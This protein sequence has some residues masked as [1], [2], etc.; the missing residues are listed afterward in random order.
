[1]GSKEGKTLRG[2]ELL[3]IPAATAL[4]RGRVKRNLKVHTPKER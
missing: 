1:M 2:L 3:D 4:W